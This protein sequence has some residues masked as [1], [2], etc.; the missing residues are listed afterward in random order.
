MNN[1]VALYSFCFS[2]FEVTG[3]AC[4]H[5]HSLFFFVTKN[6]LLSSHRQLADTSSCFFLAERKYRNAI[7]Q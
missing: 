7:I 2:E 3:L 5:S 4:Y 6:C 1:H